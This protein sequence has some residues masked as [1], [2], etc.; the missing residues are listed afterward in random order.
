[1]EI[2]TRFAPSPTG[3]LHIGGARTALF[4]WLFARHHK[5]VFILR[6]EDTDLERSTDESTQAILRGMEWL[7][8]DWDEGPYYQSRQLEL[9]RRDVERLLKK[10]FAYRCYCTPQE[11]EDR[12][13]TAL[14]EGRKPKYDRRCRERKD[15][16]DNK[17]FAIRFKTPQE[18]VTVA[19]DLLRGN[20]RFENSELDDLIILR[21]DGNPTYNLSVVADDADMGITHVIR[22]DDHLN[23]TPRQILLYEA[24]GYPLPQFA[25][26]P[27]IL[28]A[29]K[30][31]LSKRHGAT[32]VM[33]YKDMGYLPEALVNYLVRLGWSYKDQEIFAKE[34]LIEKFT[35]D[36]IGKSSGVFN[37]EKLLWLNSHYLKEK[38][39]NDTVKLLLPFLEAIG[40][41]A[42][43]DDRLPMIVDT[44][45]E[46]AGT[47]VEMADISA[48]YF[49]EEIEYEEKA[50][51]KF[52]KADKA[53]LFKLLIERLEEAAPFTQEGID[54]VFH[55]I[56]DK[57]EVKLGKIAQPVRVAMTGGTVSPGIF[58]TLEALGKER[59]IDRLKKALDHIKDKC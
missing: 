7:G 8:L 58:E 53:D 30:T 44:V 6:V 46:R 16:P 1:M 21:K 18:G 23:N 42:S 14:K 10:G 24:L 31:R 48:F 34:E 32:S 22:G 33:A 2:R 29:D 39:S 5:G 12:R 4:N 54:R 57:M 26:L 41:K 3:Y 13:S 36:N 15:Q 56:M 38:D 9:H 49:K 45:K 50:A 25:H 51:G 27:M 55:E 28:G 35:L 40:Y 20:V 37:P 59:V 43:G 11:L 19:N 52:L 17:P 47:L